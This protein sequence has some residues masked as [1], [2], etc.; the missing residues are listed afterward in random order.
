MLTTLVWIDV[1]LPQVPAITKFLLRMGGGAK[2][3]LPACAVPKTRSRDT[4]GANEQLSSSFEM[5]RESFRA[6]SCFQPAKWLLWLSSALRRQAQPPEALLVSRK[7]TASFK[8]RS[9]ILLWL[10][11]PKWSAAFHCL[12]GRRS[13]RHL[14]ENSRRMSE[15]PSTSGL[16]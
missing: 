16:L 15:P 14:S 12:Y 3:R 9:Q 4:L 13:A 1:K 6:G 7:T 5:L 2:R 10:A 8:L 11:R